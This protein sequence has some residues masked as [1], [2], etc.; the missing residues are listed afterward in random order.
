MQKIPAIYSL[1]RGNLCIHNS[2]KL[3]EV[4]LIC[5]DKKDNSSSSSSVKKNVLIHYLDLFQSS[6]KSTPFSKWDMNNEPQRF[7]QLVYQNEFWR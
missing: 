2:K 1:Q 6:V 4:N 5:L 3:E 7:N